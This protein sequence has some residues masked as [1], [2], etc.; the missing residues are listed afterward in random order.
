MLAHLRGLEGSAGLAVGSSMATPTPTGSTGGS[1]FVAPAAQATRTRSGAL[2]GTTPCSTCPDRSVM[3]GSRSRHNAA[4]SDGAL[5]SVSIRLRQSRTSRCHCRTYRASRAPVKL[6]VSAAAARTRARGGRQPSRSRRPAVDSSR[7]IRLVE[8]RL[9]IPFGER[10]ALPAGVMQK[11][12]QAFREHVA[13]LLPRGPAGIRERVVL[14][15]MD[16]AELRHH[17]KP[18]RV[19]KEEPVLVVDVREERVDTTGIDKQG[20]AT[21]EHILLGWPVQTRRA[22]L[23]TELSGKSSARIPVARPGR[24]VAAACGRAPRPAGC[25]RRGTGSASSQPS[26]P[27]ATRCSASC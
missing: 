10:S 7:A 11:A 20:R 15:L 25:R 24:N 2:R 14:L 23:T 16:F 5:P 17:A 4:S 8:H 9:P 13:E 27:A 26:G 6:L 22:W 18:H 19:E 21:D 1:A 12:H 3:C